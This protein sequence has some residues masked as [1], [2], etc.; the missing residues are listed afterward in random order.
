[1]LTTGYRA[2]IIPEILRTKVTIQLAVNPANTI[3]ATYTVA[4]SELGNDRLTLSYIP[5]S[6]ADDA[7]VE[8]YGSIYSSPAYLVRVKPQLR[9]N[10]VVVAVGRG[11]GVGEKE[12]VILNLYLPTVRGYPVANEINA[13]AYSAIV[14]E[15]VESAIRIPSEAMRRLQENANSTTKTIDNTFGQMLHGLGKLWFYDLQAEREFYATTL[16]VRFTQLPSELIVTNNLVISYW[17]G[18]PKNIIGK[19]YIFDAD[20]DTMTMGSIDN[21]VN[22]KK[23]FMILAGLTGSAWEGYELENYFGGDAGSAVSIIKEAAKKAIPIHHI[24]SSN[25]NQILPLLTLP[26]KD[27]DDIMSAVNRGSVVT[28]PQTLVQMEGWLGIGLIMLDQN[29]GGGPYLISGGFSGSYSVCTNN[30]QTDPHKKCSKEEWEAKAL[31]DAQVSWSARR[32]MIGWAKTKIE[33]PYGWGCKD[34]LFVKYQPSCA[35]NIETGKIDFFDCSGFVASAY[36]RIGYHEF[37][38]KNAEGQYGEV[39]YRPSFSGTR[40]AD[41]IFFDN[42]FDKNR[43]KENGGDGGILGRGDDEYSHVGL[44][45]YGGDVVVREDDISWIAA[46][47][48]KVGKYSLATCVN[49]PYYY[50]DNGKPVG[51]I[52]KDSLSATGPYGSVFAQ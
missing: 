22:R 26:Q 35:K 52:N 42:T 5:E 27:I 18:V 43:P 2:H 7:V 50:D 25:M 49:P 29:T 34:P 11:L 40:M 33:T 6:A 30:I 10:G 1:V 37:L 32:S 4:L 9:R 39:Y 44:V 46:Q 21:L 48:T 16:N 19:M 28:V 36:A 38:Y 47:G 14:L 51:C 23:D 20:I 12:T 41:L 3:D 31:Q 13:G 24:N 45:Y 15:G 8:D 17:F